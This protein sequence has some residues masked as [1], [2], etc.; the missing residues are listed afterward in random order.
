[1]FDRGL[2]VV[3]D[4][5]GTKLREVSATLENLLTRIEDAL[6]QRSR[7]LSETLVRGTLETTKALGDGGREITWA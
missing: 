1:M 7:A 2:E 4:R 3:E 6:T 5:A